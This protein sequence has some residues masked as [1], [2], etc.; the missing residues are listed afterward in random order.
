VKIFYITRGRIR[1][2]V[3][4]ITYARDTFEGNLSLELKMWMATS[5]LSLPPSPFNDK[6]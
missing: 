2:L 4:E 3:T 5:L 6:T 1:T